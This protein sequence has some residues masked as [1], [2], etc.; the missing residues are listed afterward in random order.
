MRI[1]WLTVRRIDLVVKGVITAPFWGTAAYY[2]IR[3]T[4]GKK[5]LLPLISH[6][7]F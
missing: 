4:H 6:Q 5:L 7:Y 2:I 1:V 3:T